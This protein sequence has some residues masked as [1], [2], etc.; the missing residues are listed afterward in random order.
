MA[1]S[2]MVRDCN[3]LMDE[4]IMKVCPS[5]FAN[6]KHE[7]RS[8]RYAFISTAELLKAFRQEG[9]APVMAMQSG[10]RIEGKAEFTKHLLRFRKFDDLGLAKS[11]VHEFLLINSH[12]ATS[13]YQ[14]MDGVFRTTCTNGLVTGDINN[15]YRVH[16]KGNIKDDIIEVAY[17]IIDNAAE[18]MEA[19][20]RM[21][22]TQL[23][24]KEQLLLSELSIQAKFDDEEGKE[25]PFTPDQFLRVKRW[26]DS[27]GR[28]GRAKNDLYTSFNVIQEN[29]IKGGIH[30][31]DKNYKRHTTRAIKSIDNDVKT[32]K[33][34]WKLAVEMMKIKEG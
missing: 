6:E 26:D 3:G 18:T 9:F 34:L 22:K 5:V 1:K 33:L 20:E 15:D 10:S 31:R 28:S 11:D 12:D 8:D 14:M 23:L 32:N 17:E 24:P 16:H 21:K 2:T 27:D 4:Q 19:V 25:N 30:T 13:S 7:S 29:I